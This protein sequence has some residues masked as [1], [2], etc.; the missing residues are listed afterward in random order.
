MQSDTRELALINQGTDMESCK[1]RTRYSRTISVSDAETDRLG[2]T[3]NVKYL[4]W[5]EA[6]AWEHMDA[7]GCPWETME[8]ENKAMAITHTEMRYLQAT[9]AGDTLEIDTW[10][11]D[12]DQRLHS[13]RAFEIRKQGENQPILKARMH[14]TCI[15]LANG[16]PARMPASFQ[17]AFDK[18]LNG[19]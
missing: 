3:N 17:A 11:S 8:Q 10:I 7:L 6:I 13:T 2:H 16:K 15:N 18:A 1:T 9:Y 14:F 19:K 4:E 5:L 12:S